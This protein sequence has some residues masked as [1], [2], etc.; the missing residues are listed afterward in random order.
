VSRIGRPSVPDL[1]VDVPSARL[2]ADV[3]RRVIEEYVTRDGTDYGAAEKTLD[4]KVNE[5]IREMRG[6]RATLVFDPGSRTV[7]IVRRA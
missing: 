2:D 3:L 6:G 5:V 1:V 7:N 4:E